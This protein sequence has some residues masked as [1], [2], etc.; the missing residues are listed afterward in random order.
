ASAAELGFVKFR[1]GD[2]SG[3]AKLLK[4]VI[5]K[6]PDAMAAHYY[7]GAVL[8]QQRDPKGARAE[9]LEAD[10]LAPTD[11]RAL[12]ALCEMEAQTGAPE[13]DETKKT[14]ASR[15]EDGK[16]IVAHCAVPP[17]EPKAP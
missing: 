12:T 4:D 16:Q 10:R 8:Y 15:F 2:P 9:Y 13:L 1:K 17:A 3:A 6:A 7:L 5:K 14:I 11:A